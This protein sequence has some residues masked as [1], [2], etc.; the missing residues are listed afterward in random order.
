MPITSATFDYFRKLVEQRSGIVLEPGKEY[1]IES[2]LAQVARTQ[3][4]SSVDELAS[5]L[6]RASFNSLHRQVVEAMTTNE[7]SWFRD[8]H[9]FE[10][11]KKRILPDLI[12]SRATEGKLNIWCAAASTGQEPYTLAMIIRENFPKLKDWRISILATD[13]ATNVLAKARLGRY[14]QLEMNR[15]LPAPLLIKY[16]RKDGTDWVIKD[17]LRS[18]IDYRELNLAERWPAMPPMD[19][20]LMRNVLIYFDVNLKKDIMRRVRQVM[21]PDGYFML[22]S[23]ETTMSLDDAFQREQAERAVVYRLIGAKTG[24]ARVG[25]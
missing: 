23:A 16:F 12:E 5:E 13:I 18:M 3:G 6:A 22:G 17:E 11:L 1:L 14:S 24:R 19:I 4:F 21:R 25:V 7:T 20:V 9:P 15:G 8:V 2:R 10:A